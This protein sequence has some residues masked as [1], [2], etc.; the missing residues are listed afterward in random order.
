[1]QRITFS[2]MPFTDI[3]PCLSL[4]SNYQRFGWRRSDALVTLKTVYA[5]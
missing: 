5:N 3:P 4:I 1:M 2:I